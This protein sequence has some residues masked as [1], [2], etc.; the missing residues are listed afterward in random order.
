MK[1]PGLATIAVIAGLSP[2][3]CC[4]EI[5]QWV[6]E[7]GRVHY[8]DQKPEHAHLEV[9]PPP[10][11]IYRMETPDIE[12]DSSAR[13]ARN[14]ARLAEKKNQ[15]I[16]NEYRSAEAEKKAERCKTARSGYRNAQANFPRNGRV[17]D[18][19]R[20]RASLDKINNKI[21]KFCY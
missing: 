20:Y 11:S 6:D 14:E 10:I 1:L 21:K 8:S 16:R 3:F 19:R 4:A 15:R 5:Y 7:N 18:L 17:E 2:L 13:E 9:E 12:D